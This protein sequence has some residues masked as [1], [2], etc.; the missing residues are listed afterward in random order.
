MQLYLNETSPF[1]RVV[2]ATALLSRCS[3]LSFVWVDP[4]SSP[5]NLKSVN[6][7]C[8]IPALELDDGTALTES[9]CI[10]QYLIETYQPQT[11]RQVMLNSA[12]DMHTLGTAKT[13]MEIAFRTVALT[14]YAD[15]DNAL[16]Q[17]GQE[18][19]VAALE[20]LDQ[21]IKEQGLESLLSNNLATLYLHV[22]LDYVQFRHTELFD[23]VNSCTIIDFLH[24]SPFAHVLTHL[25]IESLANKPDYETS[26]DSFG[27][28]T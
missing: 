28:D 26:L 14:R 12:N 15:S 6:P 18:G 19:I 5:V 7:F 9:L 2:A 24:L 25:S 10:C 22:A 3:P 11:L 20:R 23:E 17:R 8:L 13:L 27:R 21:E 1:S 16:I 4:W